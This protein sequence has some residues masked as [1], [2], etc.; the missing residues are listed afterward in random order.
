MAGIFLT[1]KDL[2][3]DVSVALSVLS[4]VARYLEAY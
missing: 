2:G 3:V 4:D 1:C